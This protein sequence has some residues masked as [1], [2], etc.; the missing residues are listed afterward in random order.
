MIPSRWRCP[1]RRRPSSA[2]HAALLDADLRVGE[3]RL[4]ELR[5]AGRVRHADGRRCAGARRA[6]ARRVEVH[7]RDWPRIQRPRHAA[8][9]RIQHARLRPRRRS[10]PSV[11]RSRPL[12][13]RPQCWRR[14]L[15][16][17]PARLQVGDPQALA[18]RRVQ[19]P[20]LLREG[21]VSDEQR[22]SPVAPGPAFMVGRS[23]PPA[24][25]T[26]AAAPSSNTTRPTAGSGR[27]AVTLSIGVDQVR[28]RRLPGHDVD[29][30]DGVVI[31][32][33]R[34]PP[35]VLEQHAERRPRTAEARARL[36]VAGPLTG[37][38]RDDRE[39]SASPPTSTCAP[40]APVAIPG[41]TMRLNG[42]GTLTAGTRARS[43][44]AE[45]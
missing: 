2:A 36:H 6:S 18:D 17:A 28:C 42:S 20:A 9:P 43:S 31:D 35:V 25:S 16:R 21:D 23:R 45:R 4:A 44:S 14:P 41:G 32:D 39:R 34:C 1:A 19:P 33:D 11:R 8:G 24:M 12:P 10:R 5:A 40:S 3:R 22:V 30:V 38:R 37:T 13:T 7:R 26:I 27:T 29:L 15:C